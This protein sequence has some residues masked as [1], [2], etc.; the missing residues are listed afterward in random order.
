MHASTRSFVLFAGCADFPSCACPAHFSERTYHEDKG[1]VQIAAALAVQ[2][3]VCVFSVVRVYRNMSVTFGEF[4]VIGILSAAALAPLILGM[5]DIRHARGQ[6]YNWRWD[7]ARGLGQ[8]ALAVWLFSFVNERLI[9]TTWQSLVSSPPAIAGY[10]FVLFIAL[11]GTMD[12]QRYVKSACR[13][14]QQT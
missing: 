6:Q 7:A 11:N 12:I 14:E 3:F 1:I 2:F 13:M 5:V 10:V 8:L 4:G 9:I